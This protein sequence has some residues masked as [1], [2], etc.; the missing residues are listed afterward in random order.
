MKYSNIFASRALFEM[1]VLR[2]R[3]HVACRNEC[4]KS[5]FLLFFKWIPLAAVPTAFF[6][7]LFSYARVFRSSISTFGLFKMKLQLLV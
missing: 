7:L 6:L 3:L 1:S 4:Q 2:N 5:L